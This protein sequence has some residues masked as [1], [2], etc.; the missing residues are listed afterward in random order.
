MERTSRFV[1]EH[2]EF[3]N[4]YV[5]KILKIRQIDLQFHITRFYPKKNASRQKKFKKLRP[6]KLVK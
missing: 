2:L 5:W 3:I 6:K 4:R 1:Y